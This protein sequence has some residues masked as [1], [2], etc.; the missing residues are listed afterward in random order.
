MA[1]YHSDPARFG[2]LWP[3]AN[4]L[5]GKDILTTHAVYWPIMLHALGLG[6]PKL[7]F[8]HGWWISEGTKMSKSLGN[9]VKPLD[10]ATF[11]G[12]DAFRYFL[13]REMTPGRDASFSQALIDARYK[14]DLA[15]D[16]GN[17]LR[18]LVSMIG[19]Y[20]EGRMPTPTV[21]T[22]E[23]LALQVRCEGVA[24]LVFEAIE[25]LAVNEAL[26]HVMTVVGEINRYLQR[27]APW[28]R[29]KTGDEDRVATILYW[30]AEALR[31]CASLLCPVMPEKMADLLHRLGHTSE[32][33]DRDALAWGRLQPGSVTVA[34]LPLFP[35]EVGVLQF[36]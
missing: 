31:F 8:A 17:L 2:R 36:S 18:R 12:T 13:M 25:T 32:T 33:P 28:M 21:L 27:T 6:Q 34:G 7:I 20:H 1:G 10:L 26:A 5:I 30:A 14:T 16:L 3:E 35:R 23:E 9:V 22:D 19:R 15:N 29:A 24:A 11:Y 4:H